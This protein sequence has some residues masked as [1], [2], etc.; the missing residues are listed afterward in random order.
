MADTSPSLRIEMPVPVWLR[1]VFI[2]IGL[3]VVGVPTWE[4][5]RGVWP[6]NFT[7]P[8]FLFII[9]GAGAV[10]LPAIAAGLAGWAS[11]WTVER[12]LIRIEKRNPFIVRHYRLA[13][14]DV[15]SLEVV[16]KQAMEGDD[17]WAVALVSSAGER[18]ES[19]DFP[20]RQA[21]EAQR[22]RIARLF[23]G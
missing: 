3:F 11:T 1:A 6:L 23:E 8:F 20:T 19:H 15:A 4:L 13:P 14:A 16:R 5:H 2:L 21:A 17:T 22:D 7:T 9:L 10:G 12:G 18:F